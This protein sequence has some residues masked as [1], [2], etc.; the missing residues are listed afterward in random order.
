MKFPISLILV[1]LLLFINSALVAQVD[2]NTILNQA[3][4]IKISKPLNESKFI[5]KLNKKSPISTS[6]DD[7]IYEAEYLHDFEPAQIEYRPLDIQP[8]A[9]TGGYLLKS[10]VYSMNA[11]SFC[12]KGYTHGPSRG[13]GHLY[14]PL[15]G[16]KAGLVQAIL[17]RYSE[18]PEISQ[19]KVQVLLWAIVAGA[20][21]ST[22]GERYAKTL[23]QL[24]TVQELLKFQ[25]RDWLNSFADNQLNELKSLA[26][27]KAS[28]ALRNLIKADEKIRTMIQQNKSFQE[29]EKI[30]IIAGVAPRQYMIREVSKGRWSYHPDGFFVRFFPSGYQQT[31]VDV[32]VPLEGEV[33]VNAKGNSRLTKN[34]SS[35]VKEVVFNPATMVASPANQRSQRIGVSGVPVKPTS[36]EKKCITEFT[37]LLYPV[38]P[39]QTFKEYIEQ[40]SYRKYQ[41]A[42]IDKFHD[43][44]EIG[45]RAKNNNFCFSTYIHNR[46][47]MSSYYVTD[48]GDFVIGYWIVDYTKKDD[49]MAMLFVP[50]NTMYPKPDSEFENDMYDGTTYAVKV[51]SQNPYIEFY[52]IEKIVDNNIIKKIRIAQNKVKSTEF[53]KDGKLYRRVGKY[54]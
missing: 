21:M 50:G 36:K 16:K 1:S 8:R 5:K 22:L 48:N 32:Y 7:A 39:S 3:K 10:G 20:D 12:L 33:S 49:N 23:N 46:K 6:F 42:E 52:C 30:A 51:P 31:R 38:I 4:K 41:P 45:S 13:D 28:P 15:K 14:A 26:L 18:K 54:K 29:I 44:C 19:R 34:N 40:D 24:F 17:E 9:S 27:D 11:K 25:G 35:Q 2:F 47:K 43:E 53:R 37:G